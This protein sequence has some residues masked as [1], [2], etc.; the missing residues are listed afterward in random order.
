MLG[1]CDH[2][3]VR[4]ALARRRRRPVMTIAAAF[5]LAALVSSAAFA[6]A[7]DAGAA[8]ARRPLHHWT[9]D[10]PGGGMLSDVIAGVGDVTT[11][12]A[13]ARGRGVFG[14]ALDL[15][16][17][18]ALSTSA[19]RGPRLAALTIT[20]WVRPTDLSIYREIFRRECDQRMLFSFQENGAILSFGLDVGG[21]VECDAAIRPS[22]VLDGR[23]HLAAATFDGQD[24]RVYLDGKDIGSLHRPGAIANNPTAPAFIGSMSGTAEHFHGGL[25]DLRIYDV[26][27][28]A[29]EIAA[30]HLVGLESLAQAS[31]ETEK[32]LATVY[33]PGKSF[34][35]TLARTRKNLVEQHVQADGDLA[36]VILARLKVAFPTA[37]D[38]FAAYV[39]TNVVNVLTSD[40]PDALS[41]EARRLLAL[42]V[43]YRPITPEQKARQLPE[44]AR[45]WDE[46]GRFEA[47]L[48]VLTAQGKAAAFAPEWVDLILQV[49]PRIVF[50]PVV[51]EPVAPYITPQTPE[52]RTLTATE[53]R[54]AL[55]RDWLHQ[56]GQNPS[57]ARI[58][59]E[60]LWTRQFIAR[61]ERE[62]P[63]IG[64]LVETAALK[65]L[66][67][68]A[69]SLSQPDRDVY[70]KVRELKRAVMFKN[71]VVDFDRVLFV[72]MPFPQGS[73][74]QHETRHRLGYMA[75]PG[76]RLLVL[77]GLTPGGSL[78]QIMPQAPL[79]GSFWRPDL[80]FDGRSV[81]FCYKPH[82]EKAFHLY[83]I[84]VDG[85]GLV[86]LTD[87]NYDDLDPVVLPDGHILFSTTRGHT[88]VRC[89][90]PTNAF[91][92]ARC[93]AD[94]RN[95]YLIS[96][97]NEPDYLP[98]VMNDGRIIYT[99][100]EYT[101][102]PLWRAEKLWTMN[103][104]GTQNLVFW[105]NQSVWPDL[106]KDAR[107][108]PG[109]RRVMFT[110]SAH[111]DWFSG[112]VG[113]IDP[114][115]GYNFPH[116]LTKITADVPWP[117][118][119][120]GPVDP[121]E[122][123]EYH[124]SG[125]YA[126]YYSPYPL[127]E[128]DFLVSAN[129]GGKF[130]L[131]L[132]DVAGDR[133]LVYEGVQNVLHALPLK[134]RLAPPALADRVDWPSRTNRD[135]PR[136]G[137]IFSGDV[138]QGAPA[139]L[140]GKARFLRVMHIDEKTYTYW[141]KRPYIST[142]PVVSAV[143]SE[144]VKRILGTVPI[145]ADGSVSFQAPPNV[146]LHFQL[147]DEQQRALQ[148]MR[149]FTGV[150]PG[151]KRGCLGCHES[152]SRAPVSGVNPI[153]LAKPPREITPP[154][155]KDTS[156]SYTRY[157]QPMLDRYCSKCHQGR[158]EATKVLDLTF[159]P[160]PEVF[161]EPYLT[162]IGR[163]S[164]G[165]PY[166]PPKNPPPG[167]GIADVIMVEGF[168]TIDPAAYVT[169]RPMTRLSYASRL[170]ALCLSGKHHGVK[171][172]PVSLLRLMVWVDAMCPYLG[173]EE[174]RALDDPVFQGV[175]W[176]A[177][178]PRIKT[179]P[180][181]IRPGPVD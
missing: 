17:G 116:G 35:E 111:H 34:A 177:V 119:G 179:A 168:H 40:D 26:A 44:Q 46:A 78:R 95:V 131:Y 54:N 149:S 144:G 28:T 110:G 101:D 58:R 31:K 52:T 154:P 6:A 89:M 88:Y 65:A 55:E 96:S 84:N 18:A 2:R 73:E 60:I 24:M 36:G 13:P 133:E 16:D 109:S 97:N 142:G 14:R 79:H 128:R 169:P 134:P 11:D 23:W 130:V 59:N 42:L 98:S 181:P 21:Y 113:I 152:H 158:G 137:V 5:G 99:R 33:A 29:R 93:A 117:E 126:A 8:S 120:N 83:R 63:G 80:A 180:R 49:G 57:P 161:T 22:Q 108:I 175:D 86:Q 112:S 141:Y 69:A 19:P 43:E 174:V 61:I 166:Q 41:R 122:S 85:S 159:R 15:R 45:Q 103:P 173:D 39:G 81:V 56:C 105:G 30:L 51:H 9:F 66:E 91:V 164:W 172:D 115:G 100:W 139:E 70:F 67:T 145:E 76:G 170:V 1:L 155:W 156:I 157:V 37:Y 10:E 124:A 127:S 87:G 176:L 4:G 71:P 147:L 47:K 74:W 53:A 148:T 62:R 160:G 107:S 162:L 146:A 150:M 114:D 68:Q 123:P 50:R 3:R 48:A 82:N 94:G 143:Q 138:Y 118:C 165:Q 72:D 104:D 32:R 7:G 12:R 153:A 178:R 20:A 135:T 90:P 171:V 25:D 75:V 106:M 140:R 151:E 129:R 27:L 125:A 102:K 64:F 167:F 136:P 132:M 121:V 38:E 163:P 92:L 77:Q